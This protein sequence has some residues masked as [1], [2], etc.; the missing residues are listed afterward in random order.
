VALILPDGEA[1]GTTWPNPTAIGSS[2]KL[3]AT[4]PGTL[5]F[6][7]NDSPAELSDNAGSVEVTVEPIQH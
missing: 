5:Y 4:E 3:S 1:K 7:I 2:A 6:K